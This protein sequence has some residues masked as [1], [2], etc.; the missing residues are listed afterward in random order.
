MLQFSTDWSKLGYGEYRQVFFDIDPS[1]SDYGKSGGAG[2]NMQGSTSWFV[3]S[4]GN[5]RCVILLLRSPKCGFV[6]PEYKYAFKTGALHHELGH[7]H[8][9]ERRGHIDPSAPRFDLV[10][11]EAYAN[12]YAL[13][14]LAERYMVGTY[15]M[16]Y[17]ALEKATQMTG[18]LRDVGSKVME[19]HQKRQ[20]TKWQDFFDAASEHKIGNM[21]RFLP[22]QNS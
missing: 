9:A 3:T 16:L 11:G 14:R 5:I 7:V 6:H 22:S 17:S 4:D 19:L 20:I 15:D 8:D 10:D 21:K 13:D 18:Y 12:C 2:A 1:F